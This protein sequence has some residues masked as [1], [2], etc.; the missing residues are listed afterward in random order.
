MKGGFLGEGAV[1][2]HT[3]KIGGNLNCAGSNFRNR[4]EDGSSVAL[5]CSNAEIT[6]NVAL[7]DGFRSEG[8]VSFSH[9]K[10][11]GDLECALGTFCNRA[12]DGTGIAVL[13]D[14]SEI[15]GDVHLRNGCYSEGQV[16][17]Y[18][19]HVKGS[20][21]FYGSRFDNAA[22]QKSDDSLS[23]RARAADAISLA[24][25]RID[26]VLWL[27]P[28]GREASAGASIFGSINLAGCHAH[29]IVDHSTSWPKKRVSVQTGKR[30]PT[31]I[32][33][34]GF[35]Y[36]RFVACSDFDVA[37]RKKWLDRQPMRQRG[38]RF[39]PQPFEQLIKVYREMGHE[40]DARAIAKFKGRRRYRSLFIKLWQDWRK[41]PQ[42][43][44]S[45]LLA[46]LNYLALPFA[47]IPRVLYRSIAS[48]FLA[49]IWAFVGF[50]AA[51][52]YGWGRVTLFLL[53]LWA[54]GG[55]FYREVAAQG[56]F[57]PSNPV[58][59]LNKDLE[60]KCGKNWTQCKGAPP[61]LPG[62]SP[63]T[64]SLDI[65]LPVLDLGQKHDWQPIDRPGKPVIMVFPSLIWR[66]GYDLPS[67]VPEIAVRESPLAEGTVDKIVRA[68]TL[69]GWGILG[70]LLTM[71]LKVIRRDR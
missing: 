55:L 59:Y 11:G 56:S 20:V 45:R 66:P 19:A 71:L 34:D 16:R 53:A 31:H 9:T 39:R 24:G 1:S 4:A 64:Y 14:N 7:C 67:D 21:T 42:I 51:Y 65:M 30:L 36:G 46:P 54:A 22:P 58:I 70:L 43:V 68:Q 23:W 49:A 47:L 44:K 38:A 15:E 25:S 3:A 5:D 61:E 69:L 37:T 26:Q 13:G 29:E 33:L 63:F 2:F 50:G 57:A 17:F 62:F 48:I 27:G 6:G 8:S 12:A 52:W 32:I 28:H 40:G 41:P 60:A 35:T 10:I 18:G